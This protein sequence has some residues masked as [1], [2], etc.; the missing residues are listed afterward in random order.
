MKRYVDEDKLA[1][2]LDEVNAPTAAIV[3]WLRSQPRVPRLLSRTAAAELL[4]VQSPY[5][6][7]LTEQGRM[8]EPI[9]VKGSSP[10]YLYDDIAPLAK[11]LK[12]QRDARE[13]A[14]ERRKVAT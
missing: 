5:I 13:R 2:R 14:R 6:A 4:G 1:K 10:V 11:E 7:R 8:P 9:E 3:K 12:S